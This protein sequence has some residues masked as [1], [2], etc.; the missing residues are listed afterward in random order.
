[1]KWVFFELDLR[2]WFMNEPSFVDLVCSV[3][4]SASAPSNQTPSA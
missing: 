2:S 3:G 1:M 4:G